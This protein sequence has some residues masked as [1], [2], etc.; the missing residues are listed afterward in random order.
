M[1]NILELN[2][3]RS[4]RYFKTMRKQSIYRNMTHEILRVMFL[5]VYIDPRTIERHNFDIFDTIGI[6][7]QNI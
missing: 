6:E 1:L 7:T 4:I 3:Q 2:I 5:Q